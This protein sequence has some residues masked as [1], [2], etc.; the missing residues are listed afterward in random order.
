MILHQIYWFSN[1][2]KVLRG[3][4]RTFDN[5]FWYLHQPGYILPM[6]QD[7]SRQGWL[8]DSNKNGQ[9]AGRPYENLI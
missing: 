4:I 3:S 6:V 7:W 5:K 2:K 8:I 9:P 1:K